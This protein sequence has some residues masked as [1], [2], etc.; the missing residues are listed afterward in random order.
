MRVVKLAV[1]AVFAALYVWIE[2]VRSTPE[3]KRRKAARRRQ[4]R[5]A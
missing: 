4:R 1:T 5:A 3:V 2:A